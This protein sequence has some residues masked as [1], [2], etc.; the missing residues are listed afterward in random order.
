MKTHEVTNQ[1][2][3]MTGTNAYLGDPLLMQIAARFPKEL[4]SDLQSN[5]RFV[6]SAEAQDLA[7]LANTELPKL[8]SHD[9]Q[10][11]RIDLVEYHPA[12]HALMRRS[13]AQGLHC[14]I[15]EANPA[16]A[17]RRHQ[18]R[19]ARF[20]L[21]A[22]LEAGHLCPLTMTNASLAAVMASP[23][24]YKQWSPQILSRKYD[25]AK[26]CIQQAGYHAWHGHDRKAGRYRC[27]RQHDPRRTQ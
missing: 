26:A 20:F 5:G 27:S 21:T 2:P 23:D 8:R 17:G 18:A 12:Y 22:Q 10:G 14:S 6:M 1:T 3:F 19:A 7:R 11:R 15:W 16:E 4:H 13:I 24:L 25:F 9:R